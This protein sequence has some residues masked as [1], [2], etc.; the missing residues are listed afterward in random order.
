VRATA[1]LPY[2]PGDALLG[3][4][5][6]ELDVRCDLTC[7]SPPPGALPGGATLASGPLRMHAQLGGTWDA[8]RGRVE[9]E[10]SGASWTP[11]GPNPVP[12]GPGRID[13]AL[14]LDERATVETGRL[15]LG[16]SSWRARTWTSPAIWGPRPT[17]AGSWRTAPR[18]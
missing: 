14:A 7:V 1:A 15:E 16:G 13:V 8:P 9:F 3:E 10:A 5:P 2:R 4:G 11:G 12:L 18:S 17:R 6:L